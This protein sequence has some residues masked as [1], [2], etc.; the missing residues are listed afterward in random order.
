MLKYGI[1]GKYKVGM[2]VFK[3]KHRVAIHQLMPLLQLISFGIL[4]PNDLSTFNNILVISWRSV[5]LGEETGESS[6]PRDV[7]DSNSQR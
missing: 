2:V 3:T 6:T 1:K 4:Y 5:L 7:R